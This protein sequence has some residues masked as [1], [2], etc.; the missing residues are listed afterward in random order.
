MHEYWNI[1]DLRYCFESIL[2]IIEKRKDSESR[3][4]TKYSQWKPS[5]QE[6]P[7]MINKLPNADHQ[8]REFP[9]RLLQQF[10]N[11]SKKVRSRDLFSLATFRIL[12][13]IWAFLDVYPGFEVSGNYVSDW[14]QQASDSICL[15]QKGIQW[16]NRIRLVDFV[17][18]E[19]DM[20]ANIDC[21]ESAPLRS[22]DRCTDRRWFCFLQDRTG[23]PSQGHRSVQATSIEP[24]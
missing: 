11:L 7:P 23:D 14:L 8:S 20:H 4:S 13:Y 3:Y 17:Y 10:L 12:W 24:K 1:F 6:N 9:V 15:R 16:V 19:V 2:K 21:V 22:L 5:K 18:V